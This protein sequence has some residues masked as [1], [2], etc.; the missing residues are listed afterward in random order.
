MTLIVAI[1]CEDGVVLSA[2][3]QATFATAGLGQQTIKQ[4]TSKKLHIIRERFVLGVSGSI[5]LSQNYESE[6][7]SRLGNKGGSKARFKT[8]A[9]AK[10]FFSEAMWGHA[11]TAWERTNLAAQSIGQAAVQEAAHGSLVAFPLADSPCLLQFSQLCQPEEANAELP[12]VSIGSGQP[13]AD[14]FL[15]FLRRILWP[16]KMPTVS[17]GV[18]AAL[19]TVTHTIQAQPGL[20][21]EPIQIVTLRKYDGEWRAH[22]L[23]NG[24]LGEPR[25]AIEAME[26]ELRTVREIFSTQPTSPMPEKQA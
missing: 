24:D 21:S 16:E 19:W 14:P 3:S 2:D 5:G 15:S 22:E 26:E 13:V 9:D 20:V 1:R 18:L 7:F 11:K 23:S 6:I 8:V 17:D 25:Q 4:Q 12:F 10:K